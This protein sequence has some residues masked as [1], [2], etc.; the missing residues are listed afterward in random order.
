MNNSYFKH[1]SKK[2]GICLDRDSYH[3]ANI[4]GN[5]YVKKY[6]NFSKR[7]KLYNFDGDKDCLDED[8][9]F[10]KDL[11]DVEFPKHLLYGEPLGLKGERGER[12]PQGE[13]GERGE[14]GERGL[15]GRMGP[16]GEVG[17][18]GERGEVGPPGER[19]ERGPQGEQ[20][21]R[22]EVGPQG[23]RG[24]VGPQGERGVRGLQGEQGKRG[25]PGQNAENKIYVL[26]TDGTNG[27][28]GLIAS[29]RRNFQN[30]TI[31]NENP[32]FPRNPSFQYEFLK[33]INRYF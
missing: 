11:T 24:E 31:L 29:L 28:N 22:G 15:R 4:H 17:P 30:I 20:G 21:E 5:C 18:Q 9:D 23:E 3:Q 6:K 32:Q 16:R 8:R 13:Q 33:N 26:V 14:R 19:G 10:I 2:L 27:N 1:S 12:G 7:K 25:R